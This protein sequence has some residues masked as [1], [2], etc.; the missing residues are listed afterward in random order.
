MK[1]LIYRELRLHWK[2]FA[3]CSL[4]CVALSLYLIGMIPSLGA[5]IKNLVDLKFPARLQA[6]FGMKDLDYSKPMHSYSIMFTYLYLTF[7]IYAAGLF[8]RVVSKEFADKTAEYLFSLPAKRIDIIHNKLGVAVAYLLISIVVT[9]LASWL[10][11]VT[12][13]G[14][15]GALLPLL[16]MAAAYSLGALFM[17]S[18]AFMLSAYFVQ[19]RMSVGVVLGAYLMQ[20]VIS[21]NSNLAFLKVISPFDWFRGNDI[22]NTL[23][24]SWGYVVLAIAATALC[25]WLGYR[26]FLRRDVLV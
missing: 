20:V 3:I 22:V 15:D 1:L 19:A 10:G 17:G 23:T 16:L 14:H 26:R 7:A 24:L 4:I 21:F 25:F 12:I 11:F 18:F 5:E 9:T 6:A 2:G 8:S 13:I